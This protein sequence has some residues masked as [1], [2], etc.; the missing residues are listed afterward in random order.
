VSA[1]PLLLSQR[2]ENDGAVRSPEAMPSLP[3]KP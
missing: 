2:E 1:P 3:E